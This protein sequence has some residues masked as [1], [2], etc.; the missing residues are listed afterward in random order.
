MKRIKSV[1][2]SL[3]LKL[4]PTPPAIEYTESWDLGAD[5]RSGVYGS[6]EGGTKEKDVGDVWEDLSEEDMEYA[7][8]RGLLSRLGGRSKARHLS[9][10]QIS[11]LTPALAQSALNGIGRTRFPP[12]TTKYLRQ[13]LEVTI[14]AVPTQPDASQQTN[15]RRHTRNTRAF[16]LPFQF[17]LR[18]A[19]PVTPASLTNLPLP[20]SLIYTCACAPFPT[21]FTHAN[22]LTPHHPLN[23]PQ[24][25][26][27]SR[28]PLPPL[29]S[30]QPLRTRIERQTR[31]HRFWCCSTLDDAL[32]LPERRVPPP[33]LAQTPSRNTAGYNRTDFM[34]RLCMTQEED[35]IR[36][37]AG[38][39]LK[40]DSR[41]ILSSPP[42]AAQFAA[43]DALEKACEDYS[44][45]MDVE[46]GDTRPLD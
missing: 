39:L 22:Q 1:R 45:K 6:A 11:D 20:F 27:N 43:F 35:R 19:I 29:P 37:I 46:I 44:R 2:V 25:P 32:S 14:H 13:R 30:E 18:L 28:L 36:T 34:R 5:T 17:L 33:T 41:L 42:E 38:Y 10:S 3:N 4:T 40:N 31:T 7:R 21:R 26:L 16:D 24:I 15:R 23:H 8:A 12:R 9:R